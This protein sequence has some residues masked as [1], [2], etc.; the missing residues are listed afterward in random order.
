MNSI[1]LSNSYFPVVVLPATIKPRSEYGSYM[2]ALYHM[3]QQGVRH[4]GWLNAGID[5]PKHY[6]FQ[7]VYKNWS[8][9]SS[10]FVDPY[11]R[12]CYSVDMGD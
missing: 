5:V 2:E 8:G 6:C 10:L 1:D 7:L 4:L 11:Y 12:I 9:S 3:D